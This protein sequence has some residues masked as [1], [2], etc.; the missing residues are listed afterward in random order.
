VDEDQKE[1]K[2]EDE[3]KDEDDGKEP[4]TIGQGQM[5]STSADD[6]DT[7]VK[8]HPNVLAEEGNKMCDHTQWPYC[9]APA[10]WP[11]TQEP[12]P[13]PQTLQTHP[14]SGLKDLGLV[15]AQRSHSAV[16]TRLQDKAARNNI[17]VD[18]DQKLVGESNGS[19]SLPDVPHLDST[20]PEARSNGSVREE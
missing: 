2:N 18:V 12:H 16:P 3:Y 17:V 1:H 4:G 15:M 6:V 8:D 7:M 5:V 19:I 11:Q 20:L 13:R 10:T 9:L 14:V